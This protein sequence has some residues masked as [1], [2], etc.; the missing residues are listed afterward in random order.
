MKRELI[1]I[2]AIL[3][4]PLSAV[5]SRNPLSTLF[6]LRDKQIEEWQKEY[7]I[8][9]QVKMIETATVSPTKSF[10]LWA[11]VSKKTEDEIY[12]EC[13]EYWFKQLGNEN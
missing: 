5:L 8:M 3:N 6:E 12:V 7:I 4:M 10:C 11:R 9:S 1:E 2:S 13:L